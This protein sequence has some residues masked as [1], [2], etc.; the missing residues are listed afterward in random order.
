[1]NSF[2]EATELWIK[3]RGCGSR[4]YKVTRLWG[5]ISWLQFLNVNVGKKQNRWAHVWKLYE[6]LMEFEQILLF[7]VEDYLSPWKMLHGEWMAAACSL[8]E[9]PLSVFRVFV[10]GCLQM[11]RFVRLSGRAEET[12]V[13]GKASWAA[14]KCSRLN[15]FLVNSR[16]NASSVPPTGFQQL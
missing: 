4:V 12:E 2:C 14:G 5:I 15:V 13:C 11:S 16:H 7:A 8:W 9:K 10:S 3:R 6:G 1:M